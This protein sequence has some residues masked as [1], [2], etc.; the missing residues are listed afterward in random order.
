MNMEKPKCNLKAVN[1]HLKT[2]KM[3]IEKKSHKLFEFCKQ[4]LGRS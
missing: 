1:F 3:K 2:N 4:T